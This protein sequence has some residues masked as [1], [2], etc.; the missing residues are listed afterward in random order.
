[1]HQRRPDD[2][3]ARRLRRLLKEEGI[4][5]LLNAQIKRVSGKSGEGV[6]IVI[7]QD[8]AEKTL[9]GSHLLVATGRTLRTR[10]GSDW[11]RPASNSPT[12]D[13]SRSMSAC[14]RRPPVCGRLAR[15]RAARCLRTSASTTSAWCTP[16]SPASIA[17]RPAVRFLTACSP[18][19]NWPRRSERERSEGAGH[20]LPLVQ[21][22]D[23]R[24][25]ACAHSLGNAWVSEGADRSRQRSYSRLY[26]FRSGWSADVRGSDC[27]DCGAAF[28]Q[29]PDAVLTHPTLMEGLISL[30][31]SAPSVVARTA[32]ASA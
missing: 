12:V 25:A 14:R 2:V 21:D 20:R 24:S 26:C 11:N 8:G 15:L 17:S 1:M 4:D 19:R 23:G 10:K 32:N 6:K 13:T 28:Y 3:T 18:I 27:N 16:T 5:V 9:E 7:E 22:P 29:A 30:F 31:A